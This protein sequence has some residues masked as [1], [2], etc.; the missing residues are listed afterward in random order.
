V[1]PR[2]RGV[3]SRGGCQ[4]VPRCCLWCT[5]EAESGIFLIQLFSVKSTGHVP[6]CRREALE[7]HAGPGLKFVMKVFIMLF[8]GTGLY[9]HH[10]VDKVYWGIDWHFPVR[11]QR[12]GTYLRPLS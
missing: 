7:D 12:G 8:T 11:L 3:D 5:F 6:S 2:A 4:E 10:F 1:S 9:Y